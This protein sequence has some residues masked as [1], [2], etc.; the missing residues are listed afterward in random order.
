MR[1]SMPRGHDAITSH[2]GHLTLTLDLC[3][4][5]DVL[6]VTTDRNTEARRDV[7]RDTDRYAA[8]FQASGGP[9]PARAGLDI[10]SRVFFIPNK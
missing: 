10:A 9:R 1:M 8:R 6:C 5:V 7:I 4:C 2:T 3:R